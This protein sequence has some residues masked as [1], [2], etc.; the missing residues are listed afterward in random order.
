MFGYSI[1]IFTSHC[2]IQACIFLPVQLPD[3]Q[4]LHACESWTGSF[5][6]CTYSSFLV[7]TFRLAERVNK[8]GFRDAQ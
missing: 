3:S 4:C 7:L 2:A 1:I 5:S 8:C 6:K